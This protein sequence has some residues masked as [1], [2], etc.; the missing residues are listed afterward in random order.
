MIVFADVHLRE[1]SVDVVLNEVLPGIYQECLERQDFQVACLGDLFHFRYKVDAR[2]QNGVKDEFERWAAAGIQLRILPGNHD[3]YDVSGRN[4][5]ELFDHI[6][7]VRVY[8]TPTWDGDGLWVPYRKAPSEMVAALATPYP[9]ST[10]ERSVL[11]LHHGVRGAVMNDTV[12]DAEGIP[13]ESFGGRWQAILCG[14]YHKHQRVGDRLWYIGSPWQTN[15]QEAGQPKGVCTWLGGQLQFVPKNWGPRI[16][17]FTVGPGQALELVGV[18]A[19]DEVRVKTVG[20]DAE[21]AAERVGA[22][23]AQAGIARHTVTPEVAKMEARLAV[24]ENATLLEYAHAYVA[25]T[26]TDLD[27]TRLMATFGGLVGVTHAD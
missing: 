6:P 2:V 9:F 12:V 8:S 24:S 11:W 5:L 1:E 19:R 17:T 18:A 10:G 20:P 15:V 21:Q 26:E 14:H 7:G 3:Q 13:I 25:Q 23:L 16:H 4:V 22:M 27:K